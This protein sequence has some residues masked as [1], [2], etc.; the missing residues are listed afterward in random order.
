MIELIVREFKLV[1]VMNGG[2]VLRFISLIWDLK[3]M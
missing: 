3:Y 1:E 2:G